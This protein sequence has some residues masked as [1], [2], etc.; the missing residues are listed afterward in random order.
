MVARI[1]LIMTVVGAL[2]G[3]GAGVFGAKALSDAQRAWIDAHWWQTAAALGFVTSVVSGFVV[4]ALV[5]SKRFRH[6]VDGS[7]AA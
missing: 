7:S 5:R 6:L 2:L 3:A 4:L 1:V